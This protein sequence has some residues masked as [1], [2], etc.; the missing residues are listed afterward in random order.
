MTD[1]QS[2]YVET[3]YEET[4]KLFWNDGEFMIK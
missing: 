3:S 1:G 4:R 2:F